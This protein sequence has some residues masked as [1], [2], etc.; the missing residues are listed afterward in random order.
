[1]FDTYEGQIYA[2]AH[3][4]APEASR[5]RWAATDQRGKVVGTWCAAPAQGVYGLRRSRMGVF[6]GVVSVTYSVSRFRRGSTAIFQKDR[7][8]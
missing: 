1:M 5:T 2:D 7:S 8:P 3:G 6:L 4:E